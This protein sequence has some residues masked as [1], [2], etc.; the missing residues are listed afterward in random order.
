MLTAIAGLILIMAEFVPVLAAIKGTTLD[1][2]IVIGAFAAILGAASL[3]YTHITKVRRKSRGWAYSLV[4]IVGFSATILV[5][6]PKIGVPPQNGVHAYLE[7]PN[8]GFAQV[9]VTDTLG[10][11][12]LTVDVYNADPNSELP[13]SLAGEQVDT[14]AINAEGIGHLQ[15]VLPWSEI[16]ADTSDAA[17]AYLRLIDVPPTV[18]V[19][20]S[21]P[22]APPREPYT[23][24]SIA[25]GAAFSGELEQFAWITGDYLWTGAPFWYSYEYFVRPLQATMFCL[26]AFYVASAAFR[27]FR[28]RS[29][30]SSVLLLTAF[31]ILLGRTYVGTAMTSFLP[32]QGFWSFFQ[33]PELST[34]IMVVFNTAGTRAIMIGIAL[35]IISTSLKIILGIDRSYLGSDKG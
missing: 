30:E 9:R 12:Q 4:T 10:G 16:E 27:A 31:I 6:C 17:A 11:R 32:D 20:A 23:P 28:A 7:G 3:M 15:T 19:A 13:L 35:G 34:W 22:N 14:I 8:D 25:I 5:G 29:A 21:D 33:V 2:F 24:V 26:L 18:D 1:W